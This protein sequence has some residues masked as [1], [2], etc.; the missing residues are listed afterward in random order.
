MSEI[1]KLEQN[2]EE[3]KE[4]SP[5]QLRQSKADVRSSGEGIDNIESSDYFED[6]EHKPDKVKKDSPVSKDPDE[7]DLAIEKLNSN[8][9]P[10]EDVAKTEK[11][12]T[13]NDISEFNNELNKLYSDTSMSNQE[14][15]AAAKECVAKLNQSDISPEEKKQ[16]IDA[17][18]D[19]RAL[20]NPENSNW[21][22]RTD[23]NPW[24][25]LN[26]DYPDNMG[27]DFNKEITPLGNSEGSTSLPDIGYRYGGEGGYNYTVKA[28]DGH[29]PTLDE[30][31]V[32]K[33]MVPEKD[34]E[35]HFDNDR[36]VQA[37]DAIK[38][39]DDNPDKTVTDIN[40][41][42]DEINAERKGTDL[43]E[44]NNLSD[45]A[46]KAIVHEYKTMQKDE[47]GPVRDKLGVSDDFTKYGVHGYAKPMY[48]EKN[49]IICEGGADQF[50][51][52]LSEK[53]L[54]KLGIEY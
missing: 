20:K 22:Q 29:I 54:K 12:E 40:S 13:Y 4:P 2:T 31:S 24:P 38:N 39:F 32:P 48:D 52:A 26:I 45:N 33:E 50:N 47:F 42:I 10:L 53:T 30:R 28:E 11:L 18:S 19:A 27:L 15:V 1:K 35:V 21:T 46:I 36:Y 17:P 34:R 43:P 6:S 41:M 5:E 16:S 25:P 44:L 23:D 7:S 9:N 51:T 14:K 8:N 3:V 49:D 37:I